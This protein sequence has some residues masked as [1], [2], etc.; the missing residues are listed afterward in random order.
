SINEVCSSSTDWK[1]RHLDTLYGLYSSADNFK[2]VWPDIKEIFGE[3]NQLNNISHINS[4][5]II[6]IAD[7][8]GIQSDFQYSSQ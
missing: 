5:L 1:S 8:L 7:Q 6:K 3:I 4:M 2:D